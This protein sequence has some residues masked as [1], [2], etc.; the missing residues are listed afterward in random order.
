MTRSRRPLWGLNPQTYVLWVVLWVIVVP[1]PIAGG[2][3]AL[4]SSDSNKFFAVA[5][6]LGGVTLFAATVWYVLLPVRMDGQLQ[7]PS[8][9]YGPYKPN[10]FVLIVVGSFIAFLLL[11]VAAS[12]FGGR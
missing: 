4:I 5:V 7:T 1:F 3:I 2:V 12:A 11:L 10:R 6:L 9:R 8:E